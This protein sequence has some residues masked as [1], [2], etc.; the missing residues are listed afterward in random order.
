MRI[1]TRASSAVNLSSESIPE[2]LRCILKISES[3]H[4]SVLHR[5]IVPALLAFVI[6]MLHGQRSTYGNNASADRVPACVLFLILLSSYLLFLRS[7]QIKAQRPLRSLKHF[8]GHYLNIYIT[9][10]KM[11]PNQL[12]VPP[13]FVLMSG[14]LHCICFLLVVLSLVSNVI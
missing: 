8:I 14:F 5:F 4:E 9:P 13:V 2:E 3:I 7:C 11:L 6:L 10:T 1:K 12:M